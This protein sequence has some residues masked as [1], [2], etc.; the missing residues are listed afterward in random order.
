MPFDPDEAALRGVIPVSGQ[1][2]PQGGCARCRAGRAGLASHCHTME[3]A[4]HQAL[5][6]AQAV[7]MPELGEG[8]AFERPMLE[9]RGVACSHARQGGPAALDQLWVSEELV[10]SSRFAIGDVTRAVAFDDHLDEDGVRSRS[11][12]CL[13]RASLR[14]RRRS[15]NLCTL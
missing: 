8:Y 9:V 1:R 4:S 5:A 10:A 14:M 12:R 6:E 15:H 11:Y 2:H 7:A 3:L 13:V